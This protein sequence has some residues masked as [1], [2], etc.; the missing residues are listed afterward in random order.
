[1]V[2]ARRMPART[3]AARPQGT[4]VD[5]RASKV[6]QPAPQPAEFDHAIKY[7]TDIKNKFVN[8]P[9]RYRKFLSI[10]QNYQ[11]HQVPTSLPSLPSL[12]FP[13]GHV[14][15]MLPCSYPSPHTPFSAFLSCSRGS[16]AFASP[17]RCSSRIVYW[18]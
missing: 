2:A 8:E 5:S 13:F 11:Q 7:V 12:P 16:S 3:P 6:E 14:T 18:R 15:A 1:M 4:V 17:S 10:L 9:E